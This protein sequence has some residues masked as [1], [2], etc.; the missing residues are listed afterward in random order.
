MKIK[1]PLLLSKEYRGYQKVYEVDVEG[2]KI[3]AT[4]TY[5]AECEERSG[6]DYSLDCFYDDLSEDEIQ[7]LED[8]FYEI[9][10]HIEEQE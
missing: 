9:L 1:D 7:D 5:D 3:I 4:Y 2:T 6:W 10:C 8:E